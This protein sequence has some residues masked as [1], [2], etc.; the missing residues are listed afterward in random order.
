MPLLRGETV[1][2]WRT[3]VLVEHHGPNKDPSDPDLPGQRSGNPPSYEAMRTKTSVYIEYATGEREYHDLAADPYELHNSYSSL[4]A[5][6]KLSL[7]EAIKG[8]QNCH[9]RNACRQAE[10]VNLGNQRK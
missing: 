2:D 8:M 10:R 5:S 6:Q 9:D 1:Q 3:A 4:P 7:A